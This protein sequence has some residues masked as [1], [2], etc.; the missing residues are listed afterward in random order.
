MSSFHPPGEVSQHPPGLS[1]DYEHDVPEGYSHE[2]DDR[3]QRHLKHGEAE[4][5]YTLMGAGNDHISIDWI[6]GR[7]AVDLLVRIARD[8][9]SSVRA[10]S[11]YTTE[12]LS[13]VAEEKLRRIGER[14]SVRLGMAWRADVVYED[15]KRY[16]RF[17]R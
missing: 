6:V 2:C 13:S 14:I 1:V 16:L 15:E 3:N 17:T 5:H 10:I 9:H 7:G 11:G 8:E 4:V 12:D